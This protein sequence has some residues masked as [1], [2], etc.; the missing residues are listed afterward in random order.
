MNEPNCFNCKFYRGDQYIGECRRYAPRPFL[1]GTDQK[2][3]FWP[4]VDPI[5]WCGEWEEKDDTH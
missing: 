3:F 2:G 5:K 1:K 4:L